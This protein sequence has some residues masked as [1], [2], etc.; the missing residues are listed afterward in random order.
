MRR[1]VDFSDLNN[2]QMILPT[3]QSGNVNSIH[4][5]DQARLYHGGG[6]RTTTFDLDRIKD[7]KSMKHLVLVP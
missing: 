7:N 3:G 5:K 4:Y 1:V 6:Y 2:T